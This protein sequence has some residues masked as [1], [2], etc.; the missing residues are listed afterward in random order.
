MPRMQYDDDD[1]DDDEKDI[2]RPSKVVDSNGL[3]VAGTGWDMF[4]VDGGLI[5]AW[6]TRMPSMIS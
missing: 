1:D 2:V 5:L 6:E 4:K 3:E